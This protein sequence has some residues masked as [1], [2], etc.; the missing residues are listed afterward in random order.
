VDDAAT[1][2]TCVFL[3]GMGAIWFGFGLKGFL[4]LRKAPSGRIILR[5]HNLV[6]DALGCG[7]AVR[8][9]GVHGFPLFLEVHSPHCSL[10]VLPGGPDLLLRM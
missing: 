1:H 6:L 2:R 4:R 5:C 9:D 10:V 7:T 3:I 8:S